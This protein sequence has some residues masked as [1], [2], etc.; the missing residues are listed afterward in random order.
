MDQIVSE[1]RLCQPEV[2]GVRECAPDI[3]IL[4]FYDPFLAHNSRSGQFIEVKAPYRRDILWRRP[5]SI[6]N[7][8]PDS[9]M[10]EILFHALGRG[11]EALAHLQQGEK[12]EIIG[13]LG[14]HFQ[15]DENLREALLVAGGLGV[16]P[17]RLMQ[18]E[19]FERG[20]P[21]TLFYG[22]GNEKQFCDLDFYQTRT[23]LKLS[24][25]DGSRGQ[26]GLVTDVLIDYLQTHSDLS[27][28]SM[29]VCGPTPMLR[30]VQEIAHDFNVPAQ[31]SVE[32][33]MACGFGACVGC[34]VPMTRPQPGVKEYYLACKD[35]PVFNMEDIII[36]D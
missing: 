32:T 30:R 8:Q 18:R 5:F 10:V 28:K 22:V 12:L 14:S 11:T 25:V 16:A 3:Y 29:F 2:A 1:K 33:I 34:A 23:D 20:T 27:G 36:E 4:Q 9:G 15:F 31:V 35:G 6:H 21:M 7:A 24:T 26:H 13:P 19:L 17:F